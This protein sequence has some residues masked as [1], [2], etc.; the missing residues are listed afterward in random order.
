MANSES[1]KMNQPE[2]QSEVAQG[3]P[4]S[5][6]SDHARPPAAATDMGT[7]TA[8]AAPLSANSRKAK[9]QVVLLGVLSVIITVSTLSL[10]PISWLTPNMKLLLRVCGYSST[11]GCLLLALYIIVTAASRHFAAK[12]EI[13]AL[14]V[15]QQILTRLPIEGLSGVKPSYFDQLVSIN[16]ENLGAYHAQVKTQTDKSFIVSIAVAGIG[17]F[18]ILNALLIRLFGTASWATL[19]YISAASGVIIEFIGAVFFY[20]YSKTVRQMKEYYDSLLPMQNILLSLKLISDIEDDK[21]KAAMAA[22]ML[23]YLIKK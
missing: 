21:T 10:D 15:Q 16:V 3:G 14:R 1:E 12:A 17:F 23:Q 6:D 2:A 13:D 8:E 18:F 11:V 4:G 20:L 7:E 9:I 19:S 22:Q 5:S